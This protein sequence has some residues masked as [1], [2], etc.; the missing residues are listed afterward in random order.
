[1]TNTR[2]EQSL[3]RR[4]NEAGGRLLFRPLDTSV[5]ALRNFEVGVVAPLLAL[6]DKRRVVIDMG[7]LEL[8]R[9]IGGRVR[10]T[11]VAA[12]L[13]D[14]GREAALPSTGTEA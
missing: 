4:L 2:V 3:L 14:I 5:T 8:I 6:Q 13:T 10:V 7:S 1:M 12:E 9:L 11:A